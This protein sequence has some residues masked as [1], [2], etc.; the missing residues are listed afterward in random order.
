MVRVFL[1]DKGEKVTVTKICELFI[2]S[3]N[4]IDCKANVVIETSDG[5]MWSSTH[6][7]GIE[8]NDWKFLHNRNLKYTNPRRKEQ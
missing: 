6:Y 1:I 7:I 8:N 5:K 2:S 4:L 3:T